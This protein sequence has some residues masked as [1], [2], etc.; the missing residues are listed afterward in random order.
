M[1]SYKYDFHCHSTL[2]DAK[3]SVE[4]LLV[5]ATERKLSGLIITD[6]HGNVGALCSGIAFASKLTSSKMPVIMGVELN[7][8][9]NEFLVLGSKALEYLVDTSEQSIFDL[10]YDQSL[11]GELKILKHLDSLGAGIIACHPDP[12]L[13][14]SFN[15]Y[16][17]FVHGIEALYGG[18]ENALTGFCHEVARQFKKCIILSTDNHQDYIGLRYTET[19][20][21]LKTTDDVAMWLKS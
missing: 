15:V 6:H 7:T 18:R 17:P 13:L 8:S 20:K 19:S 3:L 2:S 21:K 14:Q 16:A 4:E 12:D 1:K 11:S 5:K 9:W 10:I